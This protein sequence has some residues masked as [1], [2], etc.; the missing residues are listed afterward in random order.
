MLA[1]FRNRSLVLL[2]LSYGALGYMQ[3]M[4]FYWVEYYFTTELKLPAEQSRQAAFVVMIA[5]AAG[6]A[7]GGW[8]SDR[9]C[10]WLGHGRGCRVMALLGMGLCALFGLVG[11]ATKEPHEVVVCFSLAMGALGLCEGIFWTTA[12]ALEPRNGGLACAVVNTG[13]NG[14]GMLAPFF[15]PLIGQAYGWNTAVIVACAVCGGGA[16]LWLC[17]QSPAPAQRASPQEG[18]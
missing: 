1:L 14:V 18:L 11:T 3:Y 10:R 5:M 6:M 15:T 16:L 8:A 9:L 2:T 17:I 13:G 12:P 7:A 4:F